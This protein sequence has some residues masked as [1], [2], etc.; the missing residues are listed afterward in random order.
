M[1]RPLLWALLGLCG[2]CT[3]GAGRPPGF[4]DAAEIEDA[5]P[6]DA[7]PR[8]TGIDAGLGPSDVEVTDFG[9]AP[10]YP[11]TGI[12]SVLN[13]QTRLFAREIN[14]RLS[15]LVGDV[16]YAYLGDINVDGMLNLEAP[17][18]VR[19]GCAEAKLFGYYERASAALFLTHR[20]CTPQ[21]QPFE[22]M[23]R[24][25]FD[26]DFEPTFSGVYQMTVQVT[27]DPGGCF[28]GT[29]DPTQATWGF[30]LT[31]IANHMWVYTAHDIAAQ[32]IYAGNYET[33]MLTFSVLETIYATPSAADTS[34]RGQF[35]RISVN[36]PPTVTGFRTVFDP[37]RNCTFQVNF[38]GTRVSAL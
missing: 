4:E 37:T 25:G 27:S 2:A 13:D 10:S 11:F 23:L 16:P 20:S 17:E 7:L 19:S 12:F 24:G 6:M 33:N 5:K 36:D 28:L 30:Q 18:L 15:V 1:R 34:M 22:A 35:Q 26:S 32:T 8:D 29:H 3:E 21:G 31:T 9:P 14:G 38:S